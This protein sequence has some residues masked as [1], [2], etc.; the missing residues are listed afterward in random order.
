MQLTRYTDY[1]VRVLVHLGLNRHRR[2]TVRDIAYAY[3]ISESHLTKVV[4]H[5][6]RRGFIANARGRNGGLRLALPPGEINLGAVIRATEANF[7]LAECFAGDD[8]NNCP[9]ARTCMLSA[10][11]K[12]ALDAFLGVLDRHTLADLLQP[13]DALNRS[14]APIGRPL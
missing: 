2:C 6:G 7:H 13:A 3:G 10:I 12:S 1:A 4:H 11:L 8:S 9:I 14:L 5:L